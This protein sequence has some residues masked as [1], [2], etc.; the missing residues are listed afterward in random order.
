MASSRRTQPVPRDFEFAL[1]S[2]RYTIRSLLPH[3]DPPIRQSS[4]PIY[5]EDSLSD[6]NKQLMERFHATLHDHP[7]PKLSYAPRVLPIL[8]SRHTYKASLSFIP[9]E[10]DPRRIRELA[11]EEARMGEEALRR[12]TI[13]TGPRKEK[14][15]TNTRRQQQKKHWRETMEA[16]AGEVS[17]D[18][19]MVDDTSFKMDLTGIPVNADRMNW[20]KPVRRIE[21]EATL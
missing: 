20:R 14:E 4:P 2:H 7:Q 10:R 17:G 12:L 19:E 18:T 9:R 13:E 8:P 16:M 1:I 5:A 11:I 15:L 3:V 6:M 21:A